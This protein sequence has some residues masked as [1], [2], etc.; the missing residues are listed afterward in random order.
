MNPAAIDARA[1]MAIR[2][3]EL[4]AR[5]VVEGFWTGIHRSPYHGFS[6]EFTEYRQYAPGDDPRHIDWRVLARSDRTYIKKFEDETNLRCHLVLDRSRSM[7]FGTVGHTK[8]AY[9]ATF[10]ATLALFLQQQGDAVGLVSFDDVVREFIPARNRPGHLNHLLHAIE[11][12]VPG[13]ATNLPVALERAAHLLRKRGMVVLI[14]DF[15]APVADLERPLSH[16]AALGHDIAAIQF[17]DPAEA[18]LSFHQAAHFVDLESG[19]SLHVDP[20]AARVA[21]VQRLEAHQADLRLL[22]GRVGATWHPVLTDAPLGP[23]LQG[24]VQSRHRRGRASA[25]PALPGGGR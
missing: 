11:Q 5:A 21:Y 17:L 3:L 15:L 1:L 23:V 2:S 4:R 8:A 19:E 24:F 22:F 18:S 16:L 14:S 7:E 25:R 20:D 6:V 12:P 13:R 10:A 9:A